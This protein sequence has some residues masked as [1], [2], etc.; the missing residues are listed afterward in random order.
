MVTRANRYNNNLFSKH[1]KRGVVQYFRDIFTRRHERRGNKHRYI[2]LP[3]NINFSQSGSFCWRLGRE[4]TT[5][6]FPADIRRMQMV[7]LARSYFVFGR[8]CLEI[9]MPMRAAKN[10]AIYPIRLIYTWH[11]YAFIPPRVFVEWPGLN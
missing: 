11:I 5:Y 4:R 2:P 3:I 6:R 9:R 8:G 10:K 1:L 7:L